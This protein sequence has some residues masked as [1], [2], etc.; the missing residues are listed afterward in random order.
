MICYLE[1]A[2][3]YVGFYFNLNNGCSSFNQ[4]I[5]RKIKMKYILIEVL[6]CVPYG[7]LDSVCHMDC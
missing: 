7:L 4:K 5:Q 3:G 2:I 1:I 6:V